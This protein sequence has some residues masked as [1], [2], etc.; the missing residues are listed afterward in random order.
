M[1]C[2]DGHVISLVFITL[3][4]PAGVKE[5]ELRF[6]R[7]LTDS[8]SVKKALWY[9]LLLTV[10]I[11]LHMRLHYLPV[12]DLLQFLSAVCG[13]LIRMNKKKELNFWLQL[14]MYIG[15]FIPNNPYFIRDILLATQGE[16]SPFRCQCLWY[17]NHFEVDRSEVVLPRRW[18]KYLL[19][20]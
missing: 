18:L 3:S 1:P 14:K 7:G 11:S 9:S 6:Q 4:S 20:M 19:V 16:R 8:D 13:F 17:E 5:A 15:V 12:I 2:D 10:L